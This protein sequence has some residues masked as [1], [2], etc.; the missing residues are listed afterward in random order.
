MITLGSA[1]SAVLLIAGP[2]LTGWY[3]TTTFE[4]DVVRTAQPILLLA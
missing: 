3:L 2:T 1:V 4:P